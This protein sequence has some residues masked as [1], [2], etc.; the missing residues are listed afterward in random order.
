M[1]PINQFCQ[2]INAIP[3]QDSEIA[4]PREWFY[5]KGITSKDNYKSKCA[6]SEYREKGTANLIRNVT[7]F[8]Y[9]DGGYHKSFKQCIE[10][11]AQ[12]QDN[13]WYK[14][15]EQEEII[16][17]CRIANIEK[18]KEEE[19]RRAKRLEMT[20]NVYKTAKI[21]TSK[22][23]MCDYFCYK[24]IS[25]YGIARTF[26]RIHNNQKQTV[27]IA[28]LTDIDGDIKG[29]QLFMKDGSK[30]IQG[31]KSGNFITVKNTCKKQNN[32]PSIICIGEGL[33]S[34]DAFSNL[35]DKKDA[36]YISAIDAGNLE[37]VA[38]QFRELYA[39]A[40]ILIVADNDYGKP[41]CGNA[42]LYHAYD[43]AL[44]LAETSISVPDAPSDA[45][46]RDV[47]GKTS[48]DWSD[49]YLKYLRNKKSRK[50]NGKRPKVD[51]IYFDIGKVELAKRALLYC[52]PKNTNKI[53]AAAR[54][55]IWWSEQEGKMITKEEL[56]ELLPKDINKQEKDKYEALIRYY[57]KRRFDFGFSRYR[58]EDEDYKPNKRTELEDY[59]NYKSKLISGKNVVIKAPTGF[60]KTSKIMYPTVMSLIEKGKKV[61]IVSS[62]KNTVTKLYEEL[63]ALC[64]KEKLDAK[65]SK[66]TDDGY[67][68]ADSQVYITT[69]NSINKSASR[70]KQ[71]DII[72]I[73]EF[74]SVLSAVASPYGVIDKDKAPEILGRLF[75]AGDNGTP[76]FALDAD[77]NSAGLDFFKSTALEYE[78]YIY[79]DKKC[80]KDVLFL[81]HYESNL[82]KACYKFF[83][84]LK[85]T[86]HDD[87]NYYIVSDSKTQLEY[88][89][90]KFPNSL[91]ITADTS[92]FD[93][94]QKFIKD[95]NGYLEK[96]KS[97]NPIKYVF[98][99][100]A[101]VT[102]LSVECEY[103]YKVLA[104]KTTD[105]IGALEFFQMLRRVRNVK[106]GCEVYTSRILRNKT[107]PNC[108]TDPKY[109]MQDY[110]AQELK[111]Y[112]ELMGDSS[113]KDK[114]ILD[115]NGSYRL[116]DKVENYLAKIKSYFIALDNHEKHW[117]PRLIEML[118]Q[119][120]GY[121]VIISEP[122]RKD[123][124]QAQKDKK[125]SLN[126]DKKNFK[127]RRYCNIIKARDLTVE[128]YKM[129]KY[130]KALTSQDV[131]AVKKY[132]MKERL[133]LNRDLTVEDIEFFDTPANLTLLRNYI[134]LF[135][136]SV[137]KKVLESLE[138][139]KRKRNI[140]FMDSSW[141]DINAQFIDFF[142]KFF[143]HNDDKRYDMSRYQEGWNRQ[144]IGTFILRL[145]KHELFNSFELLL[146]QRYKITIP[147][148]W[149]YYIRFISVIGKKVFGLS[150]VIVNKEV[151]WSKYK[152][153][154][155]VSRTYKFNLSAFD[156]FSKYHRS[157]SSID[158]CIEDKY[159]LDSIMQEAVK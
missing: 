113:Y 5:L 17:K 157:L 112:A 158:A 92:G 143:I 39:N 61:V 37:K 159:V 151:T 130:N 131:L 126:E 102:A 27:G 109:V 28:A 90:S 117:G 145:K 38:R 94:Q 25:N 41:E 57:I 154:N 72:V 18:E 135:D 134:Q 138:V 136:K 62:L 64:Y 122:N 99:S 103:F 149:K 68:I 29:Y 127:T 111:H 152:K 70:I 116:R 125:K 60:G 66:Y 71:A 80:S 3:P 91:L 155:Y 142:Y 4:Y 156:K 49:V 53:R 48:I 123:F 107:V 24:K 79:E 82:D 129:L 9:K 50:F 34:V 14:S 141:S 43:T 42:G 93:E 96:Q 85:E 20:A 115:K 74:M 55:L 146:R 95:P 98:V 88:L 31:S 13:N 63:S 36:L 26:I 137:D 1:T 67:D 15:S 58:V 23:G 40:F 150:A 30:V 133:K 119:D 153:R 89:H 59:T 16:Q 106:Q 86:V 65:I 118:A 78:F 140:S 101:I 110:I 108:A 21:V 6:V 73:D 12:K 45:P 139:T 120:H 44:K 22:A 77:I 83:E 47:Q 51:F 69:I 147:E 7:V 128:D 35:Y 114:F 100:P 144:D 148:D 19:L 46:L 132:E 8:T 33:A 11:T 76:I 124:S 10:H 87:K 2:E 52:N 81:M 75:E 121:N 54:N 84:V 32:L 105:N 104:L 97:N 56:F